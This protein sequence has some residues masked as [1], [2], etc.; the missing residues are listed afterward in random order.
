M[1]CDRPL[2]LHPEWLTLVIQPLQ[3]KES[4]L[5]VLLKKFHSNIGGTR[6]EYSHSLFQNLQPDNAF[7][8][9]A[10]ERKCLLLRES[11]LYLEAAYG[12]C[13]STVS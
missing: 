7:E 11:K 12:R 3:Q 4:A 2:L 6:P 10:T 9:Q 13:L 1:R 8:A 5:K